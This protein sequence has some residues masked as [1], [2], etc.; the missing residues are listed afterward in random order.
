MVENPAHIYLYFKLPHTHTVHISFPTLS[1]AG[2]RPWHLC[3]AREFLLQFVEQIVRNSSLS[4]TSASFHASSLLPQAP[5]SSHGS[6]LLCDL[7][8]GPVDLEVRSLL[9]G[10]LTQGALAHLRAA[11]REE[12]RKKGNKRSGSFL[13]IFST[14]VL[15]CSRLV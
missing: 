14:N 11:Q 9:E 5:P 12:R 7:P 15:R 6:E 10:L 8:Q 1:L 2:R 3:G 4:T 13:T